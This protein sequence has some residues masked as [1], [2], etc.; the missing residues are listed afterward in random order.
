MTIFVEPRFALENVHPRFVNGRFQF[1]NDQR[2]VVDDY[3]QF[4]LIRSSKYDALVVI[5]VDVDYLDAEAFFENPGQR[6]AEGFFGLQT[7]ARTKRTCLLYTSRC[8]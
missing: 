8:V 2:A 3:I 4:D 7:P 6:V 5:F 1:A